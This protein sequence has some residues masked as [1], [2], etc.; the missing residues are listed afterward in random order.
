MKNCEKILPDKVFAGR[1][2]PYLAVPGK[3]YCKKHGRKS[4]KKKSSN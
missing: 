1:A 4:A 2:C 3:R